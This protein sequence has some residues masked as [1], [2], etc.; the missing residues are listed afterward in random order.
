MDRDPRRA[1]LDNP[2]DAVALQRAGLLAVQAGDRP[3]A[4]RLLCRAAWLHRDHAVLER[5]V[6]ETLAPA[7]NEA[8]SRIQA[9]ALEEAAA[10]LEPLAG[11]VEPAGDFARTL[12]VLRLIQG[13]DEEAA[14]L[15]AASA[16]EDSGLAVAMAAVEGQRADIFVGTV[17]I[18]VFNMEETV[19]RALDSVLAAA[20][21][22]RARDPEARIHICVI[23]DASPDGS[24]ARALGWARAHPEQSVAVIA[25]NRNRGVGPAR[26]L[27]AASARGGYLWFLDAD[28][29]FLPPHLFL[30]AH[31]LNV[32]PEAAFVRTGMLFDR[33][34]ATI[35][36]EWRAASENS[37]PCNLCVRR[38]CHEFVGGFPEEAPFLPALAEDVAYARALNSLFGGVKIAEKTVHYTMREDNALA[39]QSAE[40]TGG[41]LSAERM[42]PNARFMGMEI[43]TLR[44][45][46]ALKAKRAALARTRGPTGPSALPAEE[47]P[48]APL[49]EKAKELL[50]TVEPLRALEPL[51]RAVALEP[52][53]IP[54]WFEL[55]VTAHRLQRFGLA[56][57]AFRVVARL[58][59]EAAAARFNVAS[60]LFESSRYAEAFS[61]LRET[62][63]LQPAYPNA[64]RLL[65]WTARRLGR[66]GMAR[67]VLG[68]GL[69]LDPGNA[70][71]DALFAEV[72]L[73]AGDA[74]EAARHAR[75]SLALAPELFEGLVTLAGA[76][77]AL[78]RPDDALRCW[79]RGIRCNPGR[80]D[81][82]TGRTVNLLTRTLGTPP[83][84]RPAGPDGRRLAST[85]FGRHG[86]FGNQLLQYGVLRLYADLHGLT[87]EVPSWPGRH[88]YGLDDPMPG[89][90]L[91]PVPEAEGETAILASLQGGD[92]PVLAD[93]DVTG[94]FCGSTSF[95]SARRDAFRAFFTPAPRLRA[96]ADGVASRLRAAGGTV[97][98]LHLR[99]G[100]FGWGRFWIAPESW[101][102][103][104][105]DGVWRGLDRPVLYVATDDPACLEAFAQYRPLCA[106]DLAEPLPGAEFFTDFHA[107]CQA[108]LV[109][110]SN[111]SF[112]FTASMLNRTARGFHRP[113]RD[114]EALVAYDPWN[115]PVLL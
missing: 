112:S 74:G 13:R 106:R 108:D 70:G 61:R 100:D 54:A 67:A 72:V 92:V 37:Y 110:I 95:L 34:D 109:A 26:N 4:L 43:L 105:L 42:R 31:V 24:H 86:R 50:Q 36:P 29:V 79:E 5:Q 101:Y 27:G 39:R 60:L 18:P 48:A 49:I 63:A 64:L 80:A 38:E 3:H 88:L 7:L 97:V 56:L 66:Q 14:R 76:L 62:L 21:F 45:I 10:I 99:R 111:S 35:T 40:M 20:D 84:P 25:H 71:L 65:G 93:R 98:A 77:D 91:P 8:I 33:I 78:R 96:C 75:R 90:S 53:A 11:I 69:R 59:F 104:W 107:L 1:L 44:R 15:N 41:P 12:G 94:Y 87:L 46:A 81:A 114:R 30:T 23:D 85:L 57:Q 2:A 55:G 22:Y 102:L 73:D 52:G 32:T 6:E 16:R 51:R 19:E 115:S 113:D 47:P 82:F 9:G 103:R 17:V 89:A 68:R 28:D 83:P 58:Q